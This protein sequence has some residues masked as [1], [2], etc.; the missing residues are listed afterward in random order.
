MWCLQFARTFHRSTRQK[1]CKAWRGGGRHQSAGETLPTPGIWR[2]LSG[3]G[4]G[5]YRS[6]EIEQ[7]TPTRQVKSRIT[8]ERWVRCS[9]LLI[10]KKK[11]YPSVSGATHPIIHEAAEKRGAFP[12]SKTRQ[13]DIAS[14][15]PAPAS[16]PH[17]S[18]P[19]IMRSYY[20]HSMMSVQ[21]WIFVK[22]I[23]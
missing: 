19:S 12:N 23:N 8:P 16:V 10:H 7:G 17:F 18:S 4:R 14:K 22:Y 2:T 20:S 15:A 11:N 5:R 6:S 3:C 13:R 9:Q 21:H 1:T